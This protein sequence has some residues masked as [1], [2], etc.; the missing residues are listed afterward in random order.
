ML[1][2]L[3]NWLNPTPRITG[4]IRLA[5]KDDF[6]HK[7]PALRTSWMR[8][9]AEAY[10]LPAL[11]GMEA[12]QNAHVGMDFGRSGDLSVIWVLKQQQDL[13]LHSPL[14]IELRNTPFDQQREALFYLLERLPGFRSAALDARGN[15]QYLAEVTAQRFGTDS[16]AQVM[17]SQT[18][19]RE[20]MPRV[21]AHFED[22]TIT[23]PKD[24]DILNDLRA[25][26]MDNGVAKVPDNY[27][28]NGRHGDS[29]I[30]LAM[31]CFAAATMG[32]VITSGFIPVPDRHDTK[33]DGMD[34]DEVN[35]W[36]GGLI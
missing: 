2:K 10:L 30:A 18:W 32:G 35:Y 9:F 5:C 34:D 27:R 13:S 15:G 1:N 11:Q 22:G 14:I 4:L 23:L 21:K 16:I 6:T 31:A 26:R 17:L 8:D 28:D 24:Q 33:G 36:H 7:P 25:V 19:Y 3:K 20:N 29:A 12:R